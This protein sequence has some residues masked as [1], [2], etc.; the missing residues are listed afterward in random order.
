[1]TDLDLTIFSDKTYPGKIAGQLHGVTIDGQ[2]WELAT[3]GRMAVL[4]KRPSQEIKETTHSSVRA[5]VSGE[6]KTLGRTSAELLR[7]WTGAHEGEHEELCDNCGGDGQCDNCHCE[8][9]HDCGVCNGTGKVM[10][11]PDLRR[12]WIGTH[13]VD[14]NRLAKAA[15]VFSGPCL[16]MVGPTKGDYPLIEFRSDEWRIIIM[17]CVVDKDEEC[18][19]LEMEST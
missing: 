8:K 5:I 17:A 11:S 2:S 16:V 6:R 19:K 10:E 13:Q 3:D 18:P 7:E 1:M 4:V 15:Q 12:G 9:S 14:R